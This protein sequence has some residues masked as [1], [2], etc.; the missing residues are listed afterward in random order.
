MESLQIKKK[1]KP[2]KILS[3][4]LIKINNKARCVCKIHILPFILDL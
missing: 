1:E 4:S 2:F 3:G